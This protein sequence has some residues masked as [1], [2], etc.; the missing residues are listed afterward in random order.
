[1]NEQR[2]PIFDLKFEKMT[3]REKLEKRLKKGEFIFD[4]EG[5]NDGTFDKQVKDGMIPV[6][7]RCA[8]PVEFARTASEAKSKNIA[9]GF[10]CSRNI[11]HLQI[12][13]NFVDEV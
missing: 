7:P 12:I 10:R 1:M 4:R 13:I 2:Q 3:F 11:N 5:R 9:P 6:C 8:A